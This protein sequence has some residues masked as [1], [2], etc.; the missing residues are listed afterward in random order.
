[1]A[2]RLTDR[3]AL[4]EGLLDHQELLLRREVRSWLDGQVALSLLTE[5]EVTDG[6]LFTVLGVEPHERLSLIRQTSSKAR[7]VAA[8]NEAVTTC[9]SRA[10]DLRVSKMDEGGDFV[11]VESGRLTRKTV[12]DLVR[13]VHRELEEA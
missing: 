5:E 13:R 1:M 8:F 12:T 10:V 3:E 4:E 9:L 7:A 2:R 6:D 11:E